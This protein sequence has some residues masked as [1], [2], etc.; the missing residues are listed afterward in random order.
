[1]VGGLAKG[2]LNT[3]GRMFTG[4][5]DFITFPMPT[6]PIVYPAYVWDDFDVDSVYGDVYRLDQQPRH[7]HNIPVQD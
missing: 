2:I 6:K 7:P 4:L 5:V 1:M 3:V